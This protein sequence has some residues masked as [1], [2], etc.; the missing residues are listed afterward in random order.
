MDNESEDVQNGDNPGEGVISFSK[1]SLPE[2]LRDIPPEQLP[3]VLNA[4]T[5]QLKS[6]DTDSHELVEHMRAIRETLATSQAPKE[7]EESEPEISEEELKELFDEDPMKAVGMALGK[8]GIT[9]QL[10]EV[11]A[12]V[13]GVSGETA[14]IKAR[15]DLDDFGDVEKEIR[16]ILEDNKTVPNPTNIKLAY[17]VAWGRKLRQER[18]AD[19]KVS[20]THV[21]EKPTPPPGE[22]REV[23]L[24]DEEDR[25]R[26]RFGISKEN[27]MK[28]RTSG[29]LHMEVPTGRKA[30]NG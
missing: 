17:D 10:D 7:V 15:Q 5:A 1:D 12:G 6:R 19:K 18:A 30:R 28:S 26:R 23:E 24:S 25:Y 9:R 14:Y 27:W 11:R 16:Q 21:T 22:S 20:P 4:M 2:D 13:T 8:L 3:G 29:P